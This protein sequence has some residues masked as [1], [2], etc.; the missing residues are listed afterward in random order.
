MKTTIKESM[1]ILLLH[2]FNEISHDP[3]NT[4]SSVQAA[5]ADNFVTDMERYLRAYNDFKED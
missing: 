2:Y 3:K 5:Y 1:K 4:D